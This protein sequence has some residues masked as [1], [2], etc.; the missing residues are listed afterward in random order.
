MWY[1]RFYA[2]PRNKSKLKVKA[3][4]VMLLQTYVY[5]KRMFATFYPNI[6]GWGKRREKSAGVGEEKKEGQR[7]TAIRR[8]MIKIL[9]KKI[10]RIPS[11]TIVT[12][13]SLLHCIVIMYR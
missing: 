5:R 2:N 13:K 10:F 9:K 1:V 3:R 11:F 7:F 12:R 4:V 8:I 6:L